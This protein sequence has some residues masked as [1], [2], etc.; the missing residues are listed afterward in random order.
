[1]NS[2]V[3]RNY[4]PNVLNPNP[5]ILHV[6]ATFRC[7]T[8][9]CILDLVAAAAAGSLAA[10]ASGTVCFR[11]PLLGQVS[12]NTWSRGRSAPGECF[13]AA[14]WSRAGIPALPPVPCRAVVAVQAAIGQAACA[15]D[16]CVAGIRE[17]GGWASASDC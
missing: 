15:G 7:C 3:R 10:G 9:A 1:M 13:L 2:I 17:F 11:R 4:Y 5:R 12:I 14:A 6:D 16:S 8:A